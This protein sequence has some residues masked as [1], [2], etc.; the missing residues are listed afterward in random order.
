MSLESN[1]LFY[2]VRFIVKSKYDTMY[3]FDPLLILIVGNLLI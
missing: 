1:Q 2:N 3:A